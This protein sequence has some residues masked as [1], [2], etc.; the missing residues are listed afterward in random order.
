MVSGL[1]FLGNK[2]GFRRQ[3]R[4]AALKILYSLEFS[5]IPS[6][7]GAAKEYW[8]ERKGSKSLKE[9]AFSL[10]DGVRENL[11]KIDA[12]IEEAAEHWTVER[13]SEVDKN[14]IRLAAY[15]LTEC[16]DIPAA[17][18][19]NEAVEI[20]KQYS[21]KD[22]ASFINGVLGKIEKIKNSSSDK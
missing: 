14:I 9:Y 11:S 15:E 2:M 18:I 22:S 20:A 5:D 17:V 19:I 10:V 7:A 4:E 6:G 8:S 21:G 3:G 16:S 1:F 13:I 12:M